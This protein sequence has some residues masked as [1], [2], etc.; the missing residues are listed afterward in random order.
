LAQEADTTRE[1]SRKE[2]ESFLTRAVR[3]AVPAAQRTTPLD[4]AELNRVARTIAAA[5]TETERTALLQGGESALALPPELDRKLLVE[6]TRENG[7]SALSVKQKLRLRA[8][9]LRACAGGEA[10]ASP[11]E[12]D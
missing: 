10:L 2:V 6:A 8:Y 5:L 3:A 1:L 11:P 4:P 7:G 12:K 9:L